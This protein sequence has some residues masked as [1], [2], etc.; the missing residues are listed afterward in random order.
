M[1]IYVFKKDVLVKLLLEVG[2]LGVQLFFMAVLGLLCL[3]VGVNAGFQFPKAFLG[4]VFYCNGWGVMLQGESWG[5]WGLV[6]VLP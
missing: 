2:T 4:L 5:P 6:F 1:G 3:G